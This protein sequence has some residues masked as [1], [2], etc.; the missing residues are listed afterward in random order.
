MMSN[1]TSKVSSCVVGCLYIAENGSIDLGVG[2]KFRESSFGSKTS[3]LGCGETGEFASKGT[4]GSSLG[5]DDECLACHLG[6]VYVDWGPFR[7]WQ[8]MVRGEGEAGKG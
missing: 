8:M 6:S 4:E 5:C 1:M 3:E 2:G 7:T